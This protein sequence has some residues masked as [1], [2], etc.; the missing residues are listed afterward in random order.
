MSQNF[1]S[2]V[3]IFIIGI[4]FHFGCNT[5]TEEFSLTEQNYKLW[6]N[7][8]KPTERDLAWTRIHWR[9]SFQEG[10]VEANA[11]QKPML[12]WVMNGHPLGCT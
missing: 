1:L 5:Q 8:I 2:I 4:F 6:R 9:S 7:Y 11:R 10:L 3:N 12:L